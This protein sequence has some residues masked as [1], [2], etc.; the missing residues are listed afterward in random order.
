MDHSRS[1]SCPAGLNDLLPAHCLF[2]Q[3][4]DH[5]QDASADTAGSDLTDNR[6]NIEAARSSRPGPRSAADQGADDLGFVKAVELSSWLDTLPKV[7]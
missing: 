6:A 4:N 3:P 1:V 7:H 2:D 5:H